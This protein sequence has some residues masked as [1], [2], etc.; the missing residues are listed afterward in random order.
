[1]KIAQKLDEEN[2]IFH[3]FLINEKKPF[4]NLEFCA[5]IRIGY[6]LV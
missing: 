4:S 2:N 6:N 5:T 3:E 1:M